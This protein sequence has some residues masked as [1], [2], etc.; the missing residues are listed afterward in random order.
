MENAKRGWNA[1][2]RLFDPDAD[3]FPEAV[4]KMLSPLNSVPPDVA[5]AFLEQAEML[6]RSQNVPLD[7]R[8]SDT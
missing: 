4:R 3:E 8:K 5:D 1:L 2:I 6:I 7:K